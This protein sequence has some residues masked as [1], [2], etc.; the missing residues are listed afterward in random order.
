MAEELGITVL[1]LHVQLAGKSYLDGVDLSGEEFYRLLEA[2]HGVTTTSLPSLDA[3]AQIYRDLTSEGYDV[4]SVHVSSRLSGTYN[5]ALIASNADG[6]SPE[7]VSVVD[8]LSVTMAQG[9]IAIEAARAAREGNSLAEVE[10]VAQKY[11]GKA[12]LYGALDTLEYLMRS[13]RLHRLPGTIGTILN[14]RPIV[15]VRANGE[16]TILERVRSRTRGMERVAE[17]TAA[18]GPLQDLAVMHGDD[19]EGAQKLLGML[20][21]LD[22]PEPVPVVHLGAVLGTHVGPR[23]VGVCLLPKV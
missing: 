15:T 14:I 12:L 4:V 11:V 3:V 10:A 19:P 7:A 18:V 20:H 6:V 1:P 16:A 17:L 21:H 8:S 9:W 13:G 22:L 5:A 23:A 2:T